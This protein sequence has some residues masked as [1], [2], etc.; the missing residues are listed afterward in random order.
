M[1]L[2]YDS[3]KYKYYTWEKEKKSPAVE[4]FTV[5]VNILVCKLPTSC[6]EYVCDKSASVFCCLLCFYEFLEYPSAH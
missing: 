3:V 6:S 2:T 4:L 1:K 5:F